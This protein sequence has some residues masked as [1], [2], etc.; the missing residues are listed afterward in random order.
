MATVVCGALPA[1]ATTV[2]LPTRFD[3]LSTPPA[4]IVPMPPVTVKA[5]GGEETVVSRDHGDRRRIHANGSEGSRHDLDDRR[6]DVRARLGRHGSR[7]GRRRG[8]E[9]AGGIDRPDAAGHGPREVGT[10]NR[11]PEAVLRGRTKGHRRTGA[12]TRDTGRQ[13]DVIEGSR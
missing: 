9:Q 7:A 13:V 6:P 11:V 2:P 3:A 8:R 12:D 1:L 10:R 4:E 5:T